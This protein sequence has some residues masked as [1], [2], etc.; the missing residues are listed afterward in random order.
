VS[1]VLYDAH[2]SSY[3]YFA[4]VTSRLCFIFAAATE[5]AFY[6]ASP[7]VAFSR[8]HFRLL[9]SHAGHIPRT[10]LANTSRTTNIRF[11]RSA[12]AAVSLILEKILSRSLLSIPNYHFFD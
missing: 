4:P 7:P 2:A 11:A 3:S 10:A 9:S 6:Y 5:N 1:R 8:Q 12:Y